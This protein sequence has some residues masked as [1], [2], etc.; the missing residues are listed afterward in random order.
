MYKAGYIWGLGAQKIILECQCRGNSE[1]T[2]SQR[3]GLGARHS[4]VAL[5]GLG[6][7][8]QRKPFSGLISLCASEI[9]NHF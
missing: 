9:P 8:G 1:I 2:A 7:L 4:G 5:Q 6:E 3:A